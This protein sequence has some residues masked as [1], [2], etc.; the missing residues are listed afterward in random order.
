MKALH[1]LSV[2]D[3]T[4]I[5]AFRMMEEKCDGSIHSAEELAAAEEVATI[6]HACICVLIQAVNTQWQKPSDN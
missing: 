3:L 4:V 5:A 2:A 6:F 1:E